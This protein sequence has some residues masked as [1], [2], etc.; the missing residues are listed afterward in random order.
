LRFLDKNDWLGPWV[1]GVA[2]YA[3]DGWRGLVVGF[4]CSTVALWH[5][6]FLVNSAAH[7]FGRRRYGT[8]DSSRNSAIVA[9]L[10]LGEGWH[11]N[12]H[13]YPACARQ[14]FKWWEV[15]PTYLMLRALSLF[16]VVRDL[17][18]PP[19]TARKAR[20]L[21]LGH[22]DVGIFKQQLTRASRTVTKAMR[23]GGASASAEVQ[24]LTV[25]LSDLAERAEAMARAAR[26]SERLEQTG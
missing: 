1:L 22:L 25:A 5:A 24:D 4:F 12:H 7:V 3:F 15:D 18:E 2:C 10:T 16:H 26:R 19:V 17:R 6:T 23:R 8:T 11:N 13:H 9:A 14:G 21:R 20:L